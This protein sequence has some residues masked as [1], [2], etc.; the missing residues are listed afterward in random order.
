MAE[1]TDKQK[2]REEIQASYFCVRL[3]VET[4][5]YDVKKVLDKIASYDQYAYILH[6]KDVKEDG[7]PDKP[8]YHA[9]FRNLTD[10]GKGAP[11]SVGAVAR[12]LG[13]SSAN[14]QAGR[15]E[16]ENRGW[17]GSI[18][19]LPHDTADAK[20]KNKYQYDRNLIKANFDLDVVFGLNSSMYKL[21]L[22]HILETR[23]TSF[24]Q[25]YQ[26]VIAQGCVKEFLKSQY[27][28]VR[29]MDEV[30]RHEI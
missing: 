18:R 3:Y 26:W 28:W 4:E 1:L 2:K 27:A 24:T 6:D 19:Y 8:H 10:D 29:V 25:L 7:T 11:T 13:I 20:R 5:D 16:N 21:I 15:N 30:K 12:V 14:I 22:D 9:V 17:K 23:P